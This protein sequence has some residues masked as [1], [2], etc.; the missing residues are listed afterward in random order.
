VVSVL[1]AGADAAAVVDPGAPDRKGSLARSGG[2]VMPALTVVN[3]V[4][5]V[6]AVAA[7]RALEP[8]GYG[9]LSA[10]L[11]VLL[12]ASVPAL[13]L[14]AAVARTVAT[15]SGRVEDLVAS[16][17]R[18][19]LLTAVVGCAAAPLVASF[20][21]TGLAGPLWVAAGLLPLAVLS[22]GQGV[23]Q[24]RE[25]FGALS[26]LI[27]A[28]AVGKAV[29][30]VPLAVGG[31]AVSVLAALTLGS[32]VAAG[33]GL[34]LI[35]PVG[36]GQGRALGLREVGAASAGLLALL[37]LS[38]VDLLL[39]RNQLT[40]VES[41]RYAVGAV[42]TKV[43]FWL[44]QAVAVVALPRLADP[45]EGGRLLRRAVALVAVLGGAAA[46]AAWPLARPALT[47]AFGDDYASLEEVA[48]LFVVQG[49]ALAVLQL[50]V[51]R[52]IALRHHRATGGVLA[53]TVVL[54]GVLLLLPEPSV[55]RYVVT[56]TGMAVLT[57]ALVML[58]D[59]RDPRPATGE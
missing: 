9:A 50:L 17:V 28:Q 3:A 32:V 19:G 4:G 35:R 24:G 21:R 1:P 36:G 20:L 52:G 23:L 8:E 2:L 47:L 58:L 11:A 10:L 48:P 13:G 5:Y 57:A 46:L 42:L 39:A 30:L 6:L 26:L 34:L 33:A 55:D 22:A 51:Y 29:A 18:V 40:D 53:M 25:R 27:C 44:P 31:G 16:S 14:Q 41:G 49:T 59:G 37:L 45:H 54:V 7:S 43:A 12:V 38:N 15:G 56:A